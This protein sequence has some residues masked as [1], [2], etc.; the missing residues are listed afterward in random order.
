MRVH[1]GALAGAAAVTG[2]LSFVL[3]A[4]AIG[5]DFWYIIDTERLERSSAGSEDRGRLEPL[6]SHSGLWRTCRAQSPSCTPLMNPFW[7]GNLTVSDSSRQLLTMHGTFVILLPLS[8]ILMVFGGMTG[9]LSFL[10][11]AYLLL[12]LSGTLFLFGALVTL[13][14][15]SVYIAYSAAAFRAALCL[16]EEQALLDRV[17]IRFG[18]SLA[19]GWVSFGFELLTGAAFLAA[20]RVLGLRPGQD[21][22]V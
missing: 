18:W 20:A 5:T 15:M 12:L 17:D 8:L 22:P 14:G 4:T 7:Q 16:L 2:A 3:L 1:L 10:L 11:R 19:L 6:S 21:Q 13:A 9:F